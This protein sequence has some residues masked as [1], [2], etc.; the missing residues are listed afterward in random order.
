[1]SREPLGKLSRYAVKNNEYAKE[2]AAKLKAWL[3]SGKPLTLAPSPKRRP[4]KDIKP[5]ADL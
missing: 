5:K 1:M 2:K 3:A 4:S